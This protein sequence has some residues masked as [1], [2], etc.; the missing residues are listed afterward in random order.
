MAEVL[1]KKDKQYYLRRLGQLETER[2]SFMSHWQELA[3]FIEPRRGSFLIS[4]RNKGNKRHN[5]IIN[6]RGSQAHRSS[7]SGMFAGTISPTRRWFKLETLNQ[8]TMEEAGVK[9]W[10]YDVENVLYS[11]FTDSNFYN[12]TP[13][14]L[15]E[16][17]LFATGAMSQDDDFETVARFHNHTVGSFYIGT[18]SHDNVD[19]FV[20]KREWTVKQIVDEFGLENCSQAIKTNYE[21]NNYD[22]WYAVCYFVD[23]NPNFNPAKSDQVEFMKYRACWFELGSVSSNAGTQLASSSV[24]TDEKFLRK[25]GFMEFPV[26]VFRWSTTGSDVY[27]TNC[28]AMLCLGDVKQLQIME[29]RKA[30]AIDKMVNPPLKGP[31]S[32]VDVAIS[33]LP[34]GVTLYDAANDKEGLTPLYQVEPRINELR[35]AI[36][37]VEHRINEAFFVDL[38][39]A[40]SNMEG[41]QPKNQLELSQ[42]NA[43]RLLMLGPPLERLQQEFLSNVVERTFKQA[44]R[45]KI[46]PQPPEALAGQ[47]LNIGFI[48]ALAQ[49]QKAN[50]V[51]AIERLI[52]FVGGVA[53]VNQQIVD[54]INFDDMIDKYSYGIG[55]PPSMIVPNDVVAKTRDARAQQQQQAQ[56]AQM[57]NAQADTAGKVAGAMKDANVATQPPG[58][59]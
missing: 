33:S 4:D 29:K 30:Q 45:A 54:K 26:H 39:L 22:V 24:F 19:T 35:D 25:S 15:G 3:E 46:L 17:L 27:G 42:R 49:A 11:I 20:E 5:K 8:A 28:P 41:I 36:Q 13:T 48:S 43:E 23:P 6:S 51:G 18:N 52:G 59:A 53:Q 55:T 21:S 7:Q 32:L 40:I 57:A 50:E 12:V 38:F 58:A 14:T 37:S 47:S 1:S 56:E 31:P 34:G 9:Q 2:Q 16:A 10:C 44:M